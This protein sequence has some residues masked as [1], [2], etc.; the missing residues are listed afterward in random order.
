M[1]SGKWLILIIEVKEDN[2]SY[3][4]AVAHEK[5]I[6]C[7]TIISKFRFDKH[8]VL[9]V[10]LSGI[11]SLLLPDG[12]TAHLVFKITL[13]PNETSVC[14]FDKR[15]ERAELIRETK[16]IIWDEAP[17]M[18]QL[19]FKAVNHR[20]KDIC[21]SENAFGYKLVVFEGDFKQILPVVTHGSRESIVAATVHQ[22]SFW[23]DCRVM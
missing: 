16:L 13:Q 20:V 3:M 17:M 8:I 18:N 15:S 21:D 22:A 7:N 9:A 14:F 12:K 2:F 10:A 11:T 5:L 6:L 23:N 4:I 19:A 1:S